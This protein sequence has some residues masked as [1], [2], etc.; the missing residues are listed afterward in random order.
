MDLNLFSN[1]KVKSCQSCLRMFFFSKIMNCMA[2][3]S[4]IVHEIKKDLV[5]K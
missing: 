4:K 1:V 5:S 2:A 3:F